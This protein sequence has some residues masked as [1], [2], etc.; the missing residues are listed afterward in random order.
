MKKLIFLTLISFTALPLCGQT[1]SKT[2]L[3]RNSENIYDFYYHSENQ[4]EKLIQILKIN[5]AETN[6]VVNFRL[7]NQT[8]QLSLKNFLIIKEILNLNIMQSIIRSYYERPIVDYYEKLKTKINS[9]NFFI[10]LNSKEAKALYQDV[11]LMLI[12]LDAISKASTERTQ[13]SPKF[14]YTY[15]IEKL[16]SQPRLKMILSTFYSATALLA[17]LS[18]SHMVINDTELLL[19]K[20]GFAISIATYFTYKSFEEVKVLRK[21]LKLRNTLQQVDRFKDMPKN[22]IYNLRKELESFNQNILKQTEVSA[23]IFCQRLFF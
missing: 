21:H 9:R 1:Y 14:Y 20:L 23:P 18:A 7:Q 3:I 8:H 5:T 13:N 10:D 17:Y 15:E 12:S 4:T 16:T 19:P 11:Q 2:G 6:E 22:T